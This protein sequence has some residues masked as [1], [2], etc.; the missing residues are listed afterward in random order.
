[1]NRRVEANHGLAF[2]VELANQRGLPVLFYEGLTCS[3]PYANDRLHTFVLEGVAEKERRLTKM[4]IGYVFHMRRR[5]CDPDD[6]F[7]RLAAEAGAVVTDD[8]PVFVAREHNLRVPGKLRVPYYAVDSSCIVPMNHFEKREYAAYTIRPKIRRVLGEYLARP[9]TV[10]VQR[11]Y[12]AR[13]SPLHTAVEETKIDELVES[14]EIDHSV[15]PSAEFR[16]GSR[17]AWRRLRYFL[18]NNLNRYASKSNQPAENA[19]SNLSPYLHFG[20]I[21]SLR[22]G[23]GGPRICGGTWADSR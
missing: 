20:H 4:G 16:G 8:Y 5:K 19:T 17:E 14:C 1:M 15:P 6:A 9:A 11:R 10:R 13:R 2:A 18:K 21:S 23:A 12:G 22:G 3:Y 7:Y